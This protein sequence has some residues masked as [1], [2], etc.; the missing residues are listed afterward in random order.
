MEPKVTSPEEFSNQ[1]QS[2]NVPNS[3]SSKPSRYANE[4]EAKRHYAR[5]SY[6]SCG[7][8]SAEEVEEMMEEDRKAIE[9]RESKKRLE[10]E[11]RQE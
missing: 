3:A 1:N 11:S 2:E 6:T 4:E 10:S 7:P 8:F 9:E 5:L